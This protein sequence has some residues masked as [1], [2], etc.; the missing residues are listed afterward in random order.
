[1][2]GAALDACLCLLLV[3]AAAVTV[4]SVNEPGSERT[5][6]RAD[7]VAETLSVETAQISYTLRPVDSERTDASPAYERTAHGTLVSLLA[8]ATVS[9]V[10]V[11]DEPLTRTRDG[12]LTAVLAVVRERLPARTQV[13]VEFSPYPGAHLGRD[14]AVGPTPPPNADIH[15]ATVRASSGVTALE[16]APGTATT[17]G[18]DGL[19]DAVATVLVDSLFPPE[20]G[21]LALAG[22][23]PIESLVEHRY[24][25]ASEHYRVETRDAVDRGDTRT[26]NRRLVVAMGDR[27]AEDLRDRFESAEAAA[28]SLRVGDVNI[29]VRTWSA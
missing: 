15:A 22:D 1:M 12:F 26:A 16:N 28:D 25:R 8:R 7:S 11:D 5:G 10:Q 18:F 2:T 20:E 27:V 21:R 14:I 13:V 19:G 24:A 6:D 9:T 23:P 17:D 29:S 3:S 4:T